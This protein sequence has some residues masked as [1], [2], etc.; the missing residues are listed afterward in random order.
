MQVRKFFEISIHIYVE[1]LEDYRHPDIITD[2]KRL[3]LDLFYPQL[4]LAVEYQ[5]FPGNASF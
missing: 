2:G 1:I 4:K 5:V 3:E